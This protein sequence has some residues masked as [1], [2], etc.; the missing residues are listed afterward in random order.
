MARTPNAVLKPVADVV[1]ND[2]AVA[3]IES[4]QEALAVMDQEAQARVRAVALSVGYEGTLSVGALEGEIRFYQ[5]RTVEAILETGK[6]LLVLKEMTPHGEFKQR[7][8]MLGFSERTAQ[9]FMQSA[10]KTAKSA[11]LAVL[12]TQVKSAS[13]FLELVT[14]DDD[15]LES[16]KDMDDIDRMSAS[17]LRQALRQAKEDNRFLAEKRDKESQRADKLEKQLRSGPSTQPLDE[18]LQG[19]CADINKANDAACEALLQAKQQA[20]ALE[21]WWLEEAAKQPGYSPG[22]YVPMP[23]EVK[24]AAQKLYDNLSRLTLSAA[25]LRQELWDTYGQ[26]LQAFVDTTAA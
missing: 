2:Q 22:D 17:E 7:V 6:R 12:S 11:N 25:A 9:R 15:T 24:A 16:L 3:R 10:A 13:A 26:D 1:L 4:A 21:R 23:D 18:R 8:E 20:Q 19:F 14:H 5:R